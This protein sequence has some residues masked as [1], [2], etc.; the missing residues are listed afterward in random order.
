MAVDIAVINGLNLRRLV[1]NV[2]EAHGWSVEFFEE[3]RISATTLPH[4]LKRDSIILLDL[5]GTDNK[6]LNLVSDLR[7]EQEFRGRLVVLSFMFP[8]Q[9]SSFE[10]HEVLDTD[11]CFYL[12]L[13][14]LN[15]DLDQ[16]IV[17]RTALSDHAMERVRKLLGANRIVRAASALKHDS[18]NKFGLALAH[19][20]TLQ[21]LSYF[22]EPKVDD[23]LKEL[24]SVTLHLTD[25]KVRGIRHD[26]QDLFM[27]AENWGV[28]NDANNLASL[29]EC[30]KALDDWFDMIGT[31]ESEPRPDM[32][33]IFR[34]SKRT[35]TSVKDILEAVSSLKE[36][37]NQTISHAK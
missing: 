1:A 21:K 4:E 9:I 33:E 25:E 28:P 31:I 5:A 30:W 2:A 22:R 3:S 14:C 18:G 37:A 32:A 36:I 10:G 17:C 26:V 27:F 13:P 8:A 24:R 29:D 35:Q 20:R 11:G 15:N 23:V 16:L 34:R 19:F 12:R 6:T 7:L